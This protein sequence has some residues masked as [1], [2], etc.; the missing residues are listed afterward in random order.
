MTGLPEKIKVLALIPARGGSKGLPRKNILPV[1]DRPLI[2]W[3][4][5]AARQASCISCVVL[6]SDDRE[7]IAEALNRG[8]EVPFKRPAELASDTASSMDVVLH[9]LNQ[10]PGYEYVVPL[11]PTSPLRTAG[12]ID[13]AFNLMLEKQAPACVSVCSVEESPYWMYQFEG[14]S[15]LRSVLEAPQGVTR[16]QDLPDV[17]SLNGAIYIARVDWLLRQRSFVSADTVGYVMPKER[18]MDID[19]PEDYQKLNEIMKNV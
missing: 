5:E 17:Y 12:D 3:T 2:A 19:T 18:S 4:I 7:I 13:A 8:C 6:S 1:G 14:Q 9:A 16:R 11:Q 10:M 15:Y